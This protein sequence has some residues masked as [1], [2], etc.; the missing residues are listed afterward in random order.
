MEKV[1]YQL[2]ICHPGLLMSVKAHPGSKRSYIKE[3]IENNLP[4][5]T[6]DI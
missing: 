6:P 1:T 5:V 3:E 2:N 4:T